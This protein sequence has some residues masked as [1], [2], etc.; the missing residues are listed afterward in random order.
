MFVMVYIFYGFMY[1]IFGCSVVLF[2][3]LPRGDTWLKKWI[4]KVKQPGV[5]LRKQLVKCM[6]HDGT[7]GC[8]AFLLNAF[9]DEIQ[10][11]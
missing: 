7:E 1:L 4:G 5:L 9:F 10:R 8:S 6:S 3:H 2:H 11:N